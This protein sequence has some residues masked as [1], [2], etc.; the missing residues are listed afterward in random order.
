[1]GTFLTREGDQGED[2]QWGTLGY[3]DVA[4]ELR[5]IVAEDNPSP[6][7]SLAIQHYADLIERR[8]VVSPQI[9][10]ACRKIYAQ[11]RVA[12]DLVTEY[13]EVPV[14]A[15]AFA[16]FK[17][18]HEGLQ[19]FMTR[20]SDIHF[21]S[22]K[23]FGIKEFQVAEPRWN[24]T[25]PVKFW[26]RHRAGKLFLRLEVGPVMSS[27]DFDRAA[28]VQELRTRVKGNEREVKPLF[29]RIRT[30]S[31]A[32]SEEPDAQEIAR[33]MEELWAT[34]GGS[35]TVNA[36]MEAIPASRVAPRG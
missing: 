22:N 26:F 28:Y 12:L 34:I 2:D 20:S 31:R 33:A 25:C 10:D 13:G 11:H 30:H 4:S 17:S 3:T 36:V 29:T 21:I 18:R 8:I 27:S 16:E 32:L 7:V 19:D 24:T 1:M 15:E 23:W 6:A 35:E 9:I 5:R 14:L